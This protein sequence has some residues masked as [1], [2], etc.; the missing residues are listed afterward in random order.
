MLVSLGTVSEA[1][2]ERCRAR[3]EAA[4][5]GEFLLIFVWAISD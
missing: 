3:C 2:A 1:V 4:N 5:V